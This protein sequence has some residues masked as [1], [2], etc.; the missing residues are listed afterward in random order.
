MTHIDPT[1][2]VDPKAELDASV[3]IGPYS[4]IG[5]GVQIAKNCR[6]HSHV[7]IK[8]NT[9]IGADNQFFHA[10]LI[11]EAPQDS[12]FQDHPESKIIIGEGN[13]FR[14]YVQVHRS[15]L[16]QGTRIGNHNFIMGLVHLAHD[17]QLGD[18][19]TMIQNSILGGH[20]HVGDYSYVSSFVA[21]HPHCSI[22]SASIVGGMARINQD[23]PP[24]VIVQGT[25]RA[26]IRGLN[27]LGMRRAGFSLETRMA[28]KKAYKTL[29]VQAASPLQG[30]ALVEKELLS[31]Y[32]PKSEAHSKLRAMLDFITRSKR[33][34]IRSSERQNRNN[35]EDED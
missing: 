32:D 12:G 17:I 8:G 10:C 28:I 26:R 16:E 3:S 23:V 34:M 20:A 22:G 29:F 25:D 14:E 13:T 15:V 11:G 2:I 19:N 35:I 18:H 21:V 30:A 1:A 4:I 7:H 33:G 31:K 6:I 9:Q 24:Y 27:A 5:P